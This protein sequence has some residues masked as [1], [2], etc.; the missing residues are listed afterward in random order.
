MKTNLF[1]K[2]CCQ[3][4]FFCTVGVNASAQDWVTLNN[5]GETNTN[6][7]LV[8]SNEK[9]MVVRFSVNAYKLNETILSVGK[10]VNPV[11]PDGTP[12]TEAGAPNLHKLTRSILIP[13]N[14][15]MKVEVISSE[16]IEISNILIAPS[17]GTFNRKIK[18]ETVPYAYNETYQQNAFYPG[19]LVDLGDP[20]VLRD[21]RGQTI[22]AY[23]LQYN[24]ISK[25]LRIYTTIV[26]KITSNN[27][28]SEKNPL[29][30]TGS[31]ESIDKEFNDTYK[32]HFLN[33]STASSL[34]PTP[35]DEKGKMLIISRVDCI[36]VMK[37]FIT[38]KKLKGIETEIVG[39]DVVG[40]SSASILTYIKNYYT[41]NPTLKFVLF[42][43]DYE[44]ITAPIVSEKTV[45]GD[46]DNTNNA[47]P[48]DI[49]YG[50]L[51]GTDDYPEI[52]VGRFSCASVADAQTQVD[53]TIHYERDLTT[54]DTWL[55]KAATFA[56][57]EAD[58]G[59]PL[60]YTNMEY[61]QHIIIPYLKSKVYNGS[62]LCISVPEFDGK[63]YAAKDPDLKIV[64]DTVN[65]GRS[66]IAMSGE[67]D[68]TG[69]WFSD[70]T[71]FT[72]S[73][74]PTL[75]NI[76]KLPHL[77]S[78]ACQVGGFN[79]R[80]CFAE[81][82]LRAK[83]GGNTGAITAY[84][85]SCD[86]I[87]DPPYSQ[88]DEAYSILTGQQLATNYKITAGGIAYNSSMKMMDDYNVKEGGTFTNRTL[89]LFGD[90]S[91]V[92]NTTNLTDMIVSHSPTVAMGA[93]SFSVNCNVVNAL[94]SLTVNGEIVSTAYSNG[95]VN[96]LAISPALNTS[97]SSI[98][99]TVTAQ[100][101]VTYMGSAS[102]IVTSIENL[103]TNENAT[104]FYNP[105]NNEVLITD[106][107]NP[108]LN[109]AIY[110]V[111]GR[112]VKQCEGSKTIDVSMLS[113]GL[114]VVN[115]KTENGSLTKKFVKE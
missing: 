39:I 100:N 6:V 29:I 1:I 10:A 49:Y 50:N 12:I 23:P 99:I 32:N 111:T 46:G 102:I 73:T 104:I 114:F 90:P 37:P 61:F 92:L 68:Y 115:L 20:Y 79:G 62:P 4:C 16:F 33:Y 78:V 26:V 47:G 69:F 3:L 108:T 89:I 77:W 52:F 98:Q 14:D 35:I 106:I 110:D 96:N 60:N 18:P 109:V 27:K 80:T 13:D 66:S 101:K 5:S 53:R 48:S 105:L 8:S 55:N 36:P 70:N 82:M 107:S 22:H 34:L 56:N 87:W 31:R 95:S 9:E 43:G 15:E 54:K 40:N 24:P 64:A 76:D 28:K 113:K 44:D 38:W 86:Q 2:I 51:V 41:N 11:I 7:N 81:A 58:K 63:P 83:N 59:G 91:I 112:L 72:T 19:K 45:T 71:G 74:V 85:G 17:K 30:Q 25:T 67:G 93:T 94:I 57:G 84:M 103:S 42:V 75:K 97:A 88:Q 21:F 65:T